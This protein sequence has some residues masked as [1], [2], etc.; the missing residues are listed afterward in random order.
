MKLLC[1][2][3]I[4]SSF[5]Y[6][7][8]SRYFCE[9]FTEFEHLGV[10]WDVS[11]FFSNNKFLKS[12]KPEQGVIEFEKIFALYEEGA[13]S[14]T[15]TMLKSILAD[16]EQNLFRCA[17]RNVNF[18]GGVRYWMFFDVKNYGQLIEMMK[19]RYGSLG[20]KIIVRDKPMT[21][22]VKSIEKR[23]TGKDTAPKKFIRWCRNQQ[24]GRRVT[25]DIIA[26]EARLSREDFKNLKKSPACREILRKMKADDE[27]EEHGVY[28]TI[29]LN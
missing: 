18:D 24:P 7:G 6:S 19:K 13:V 21:L 2:H 25:S 3:Q 14:T 22:K 26:I 4:F 8:I 15:E 29:E 16:V 12:L 11:C 27:P 20:A 17:I 1:D 9:L 28:I 10:Q 5:A 23:Q